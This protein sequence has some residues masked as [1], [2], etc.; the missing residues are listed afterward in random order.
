[1][2]IFSTFFALALCCFA[3]EIQNVTAQLIA[4]GIS[5]R[6]A[7]E[8]SQERCPQIQASEHCAIKVLAKRETAWDACDA[9]TPPSGADLPMHRWFKV[10]GHCT[11]NLHGIALS[12]PMPKQIIFR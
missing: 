9:E 8:A 5:V 7:V 6:L 1:M 4:K 11:F 2:N 3:I 10:T 12:L